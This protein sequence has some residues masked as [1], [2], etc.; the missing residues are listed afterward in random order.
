[1]IDNE[2][3]ARWQGINRDC[4][5]CGAAYNRCDCD[6]VGIGTGSTPADYLNDDA[7]CDSLLDTLVEKGFD[8]ELYYGWDD[9][10]GSW[11]FQAH[12]GKGYHVKPTRRE[13]IV[14]AVLELIEKEAT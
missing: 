5:N 6:A 4:G 14:A 13:A 2:K 8:P 1:M 9:G 12:V 10:V 11:Y 7:A 3:L